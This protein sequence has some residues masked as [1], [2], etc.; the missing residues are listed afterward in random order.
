MAVK[1]QKSDESGMQCG[2]IGYSVAAH[3]GHESCRM[4]LI[5]FLARWHTRLVNQALVWLGLIN[6]HMLI[7]YL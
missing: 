7:S 6:L 5:R 4:G 3:A 1:R 2:V